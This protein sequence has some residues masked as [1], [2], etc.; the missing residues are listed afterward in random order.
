MSDDWNLFPCS[1]GEHSAFILLDIGAYEV[2]EQAPSSLAK[3][4]L[5]YKSPREDGLPTNEEFDQVKEIEDRID[6]F[7]QSNDDWYVGRV[8]V[9]GQRVFYVYTSREESEWKH[10]LSEVSNET[11]YDLDLSFLEDPS[12]EIYEKELYPNEDDWQVIK[13]LQVI[14][15]LN[16]YGDDGSE[17][18]KVD[19][20]VY[21]DDKVSASEF[22]KWAESDR[23]TEDRRFSTRTE[24]GNIVFAY[25]IVDRF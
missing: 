6:G 11:H 22:I 9:D 4:W 16:S 12:H 13:D 7:S 20:W 10:F 21:F 1:I 18:R 5:T 8:T 24:D 17:A 14:D 15:A 19:H 2:I 3:I 23:F 25:I